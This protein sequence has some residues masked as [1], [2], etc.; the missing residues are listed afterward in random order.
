MSASVFLSGSTGTTREA[1]GDGSARQNRP[2]VISARAG[3]HT[4]VLHFLTSVFQAPTRAEFYASLE[5]PFYEPC[6]R[7]LVKLGSRMVGHVL[8]THRVMQFGPVRIPAGKLAWLGL[9]PA[10]RGQ[11]YGR[12][13]LV[14]A[15]KNL[16]ADGALVGL[17][18]TRVPHFFRRA[19]WALCGRRYSCRAGTRD[20]LSE[21]SARGLH[22]RV[23]K[24]FS[25]RPWRRLEFPALVRTYRENLAGAYGPL[26]RTEAYWDWLIRRKAYDQIYVALDGPDLLELEELHAPVV[27]YAVTCGDRIVELLSARGQERAGVQLLAR[28]CGEAIERDYHT[29]A[30]HAP[31]G[32]RLHGLFSS[33]GGHCEDAPGSG[34]F[35]MAKLF[36]PVKLLRLLAGQLHHRA[37]SAGLRLPVE[38]GLLV[39]GKK[40]RVA[41]GRQGVHAV[42]RSLGSSH[43]ELNVAEF[44]R[45]LLGH[46]DWKRVV[47]ER[48]ITGS[49]DSALQSGRALFPPLPLWR[50][51]LDDLLANGQ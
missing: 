22:H 34:E 5:D 19:G 15:E 25:I 46:L 44:T 37:E 3:D 51:A 29:I 36:D 4:A 38:L 47:A 21:L 26:E 18:S 14:A 7:L 40:Y 23:R 12:R 13:L 39:E 31:P 45:L 41:V 35:L 28:A 1:G 16:A 6:N 32:D 43:L 49:D 8:L 48:R 17:L 2:V 20:V 9:S 30:V 27:G 11:G 50:P 42:A 33:A 10:I 24:R